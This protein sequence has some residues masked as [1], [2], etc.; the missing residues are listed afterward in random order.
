M[1]KSVVKNIGPQALSPE[2]N[3]IVLFNTDATP[4]LSEC[5]VLQEVDGQPTFNLHVGDTI[6][7]DDQ[8]YTIQTMGPLANKHLNEMAHVSVMFKEAPK[9]NQIANAL[10][11]TP[12]HFPTIH[13]GT[14]ITYS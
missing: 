6:S 4:G 10:Y 1:I 12:H 11:V 14:T 2:D 3:L 8:V 13:E 9:E 7:F 5:C